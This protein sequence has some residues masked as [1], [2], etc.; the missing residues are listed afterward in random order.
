MPIT[1][2]RV[3]EDDFEMFPLEHALRELGRV[4]ERLE[5]DASELSDPFSKWYGAPY[6]SVPL[7]MQVEA[8]SMLVGASFVTGQAMINRTVRLLERMRENGA[9]T[10]PQ[11]RR[12]LL[13][14]E[15]EFC[16]GIAVIQGIND[17]ANFF[18]HH[19]EWEPDWTGPRN[20]NE[21][22]TVAA[23]RTLGLSPQN[24]DN[25]LIGSRALGLGSGGD[26]ATRIADRVGDWRKRLATRL[27]N[28]LGLGPEF[29][30]EEDAEDSVDGS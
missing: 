23:I 12:R 4:I 28:D 14:F 9:A 25:I 29:N 8:L 13:E 26:L 18:K 22:H 7:E 30:E 17:L 5:N 3:L 21:A 15:S 1:Y 24:P 6:R 27:R 16:D 19:D 2:V 11:G 20:P 10:I